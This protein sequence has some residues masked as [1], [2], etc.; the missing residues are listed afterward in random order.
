[1][2]RVSLLNIVPCIRRSNGIIF[3]SIYT[4][5]LFHLSSSI[6]IVLCRINR[7]GGNGRITQIHRDSDGQVTSL[8]VKYIV[9]AGSCD[10][11]L[12]PNFVQPYSDLDR[13]S[14]R[15]RTTQNNTSNNENLSDNI[16]LKPPKNKAKSKKSLLKAETN[17]KSVVKKTTIQK[18]KTKKSLSNGKTKLLGTVIAPQKISLPTTVTDGRHSSNSASE[19]LACF[20]KPLQT[21]NDKKMQSASQFVV[22]ITAPAPVKQT[23]DPAKMARQDKFTKALM[24]KLAA[25]DMLEVS[26]ILQETGLSR[27]EFSSQEIAE[28]VKLLA[29][30]GKIMDSDGVLYL[31]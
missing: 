10:T 11:F 16:E 2:G 15:R 9:A 13:G 26:Q 25:S 22:E 30:E 27:D 19:H 20:N 8:D 12:A 7:P 31:I 14:R 1:M 17:K 29:E 23:M 28:F 18:K 3:E 24:H 4:L 6:R 5:I 21:I